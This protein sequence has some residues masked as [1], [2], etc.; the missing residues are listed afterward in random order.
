MLTGQELLIY[1]RA[2]E[3]VKK[4]GV[5]LDVAA[6]QFARSMANGNELVW[7]R[8]WGVGT[9]PSTPGVEGRPGCPSCG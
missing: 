5:P 2:T 1:R 9:C 7:K 4:V 8:R 6:I 3:A